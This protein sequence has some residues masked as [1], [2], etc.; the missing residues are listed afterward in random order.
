MPKMEL[1]RLILQEGGSLPWDYQMQNHGCERSKPYI[2][3]SGK[4]APDKAVAL[5]SEARAETLTIPWRD[6]WTLWVAR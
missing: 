4:V 1:Q 3:A 2:C 5:Q 6:I